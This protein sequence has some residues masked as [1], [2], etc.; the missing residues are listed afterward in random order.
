VS[1]LADEAAICRLIAASPFHLQALAAARALDLPDCWIGAGFV[2]A[3]VWDHLHGFA[4]PTPL[5][6]IDVVWFDPAGPDRDLDA[7]LERQLSAAAPGL[8]WSVTNQARMHERNGD[9]PYRSTSDAIRHWPE[10]AT[11]VAVALSAEGSICL[12]APLGIADLLAMIVRPTPHFREHRLADYRERQ[13]RKS[14]PAIWPLL[15]YADE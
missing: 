9:R 2:R 14:W 8:P 6:D 10:T 7:A 11:A 13:Q 3:A 5:A 1:E 12:D 4:L 15:R